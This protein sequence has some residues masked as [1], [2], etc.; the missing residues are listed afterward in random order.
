MKALTDLSEHQSHGFKRH[1]VVVE[2]KL[3]NKFSM[4]PLTSVFAFYVDLNT[5]FPPISSTITTARIV[6]VIHVENSMLWWIPGILLSPGSKLN[7]VYV[8]ILRTV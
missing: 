4:S 1:L 5:N 3:K 8:L 6:V 7:C 2:M